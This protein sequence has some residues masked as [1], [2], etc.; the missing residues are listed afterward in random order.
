[1]ATTGCAAGNMAEG[2]RHRDDLGTFNE[3]NRQLHINNH[4]PQFYNRDL[5]TGDSGFG[6]VRHKRTGVMGADNQPEYSINREQ[7]ADMISKLSIQ[8]PNVDDVST[9]VTDEEV[10]I[11]YET[12]SNNRNETADQVKKMA[13]SV[14]PSWFEIYVSDNPALRKNIENF[15]TL[16]TNS[17]DI[18]TI[19]DGVIKQM[20]TSPQGDYKDGRLD[21]EKSND[22][23][24]RSNNRQK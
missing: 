20:R 22:E 12:D 18:D 9:L 8:V 5:D 23:T 16:T 1:M 2:N 13:M 3:P 4:E 19:I 6:Y 15:A 7:V 11:V 24:M 21:G 14:V 17:R 10:L